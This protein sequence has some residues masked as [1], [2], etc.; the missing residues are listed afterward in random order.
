MPTIRER[1]GAYQVLI[2]LQGYKRITETF[3]I[4]D[5]VPKLQQ[6]EELKEWGKEQER[7]LRMGDVPTLRGKE[8][9]EWTLKRLIERYLDCPQFNEKKSAANERVAL[10]AFL[11]CDPA[12]C[13]KTLDQLR[14]KD[15]QEYRDWR[16]EDVLPST[17]RREL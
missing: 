12:L 9:K 15:F 16:L 2:R 1:S 4:L 7:K 10:E 14:K 11:Y 5:K 3:P 6:R 8:L 17:L 13:S